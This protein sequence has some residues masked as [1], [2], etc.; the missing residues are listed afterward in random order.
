MRSFRAPCETTKPAH[1]AVAGSA[2]AAR[3]TCCSSAAVIPAYTA[4]VAVASPFFA[5]SDGA[6]R[7]TRTNAT[8]SLSP[9][10]RAASL[11]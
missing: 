6:A 7:P 11:P 2:N 3:K 1:V 9:P 8:P 5:P 10:P 4:M